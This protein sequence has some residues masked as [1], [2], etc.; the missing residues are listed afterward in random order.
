MTGMYY[1]TAMAAPLMVERDTA[2][3]E[4]GSQ[5]A[6]SSDAKPL[7][8]LI[9]GMGSGTYARQCEAYFGNMNIEGVEIDEKIT[10]LSRKYFDLPEDVEV[11]TYDGRAY[12]QA[13]DTKYDVIMVDAYQDITIPFQMSSREFFTQVRDHLKDGGVMVVNMNMTSE[14]EGNINDYLTDTIASVFD[15]VY[16]AD[17]DGSTNRELFASQNPRISEIFYRNIPDIEDGEFRRTMRNVANRL[18][19]RQGGDYILT[20]DKAPV[21]LLGI[22]VIDGLIQ[23]EASY[24]KDILDEEGIGGLLDRLA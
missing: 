22:Q 24:Y 5:D 12:L 9:L 11:T 19:P 23:D 20:D 15:T 7:D 2:P 13:V 17:V 8:V 4:T 10:D 6:E 1:D 3:P 14:E 18:V 16:T 21:E